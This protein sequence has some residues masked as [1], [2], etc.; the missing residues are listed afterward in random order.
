MSKRYYICYE[1][2]H[3]F[4]SEDNQAR[5]EDPKECPACHSTNITVYAVR[6]SGENQI[7]IR[8]CEVPSGNT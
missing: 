4:E 2:G 1:C 6:L 7:P 3:K 5:S 8:G